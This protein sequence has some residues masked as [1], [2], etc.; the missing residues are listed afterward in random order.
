MMSTISAEIEVAAPVRV[1]YDQ[2][3]QFEE[4]PA[5]MRAVAAVE[6]LDDRT[7]RWVIDIGGMTRR[8]DA[9]IIDQVPDDHI[10]WESVDETVHHGRVDFIPIDESHTRVSLQMQW[11]PETFLERA[12]AALAIDDN[13][14]RMDLERFKDIVEG[15]G[16]LAA[17][18]RGEIHGADV[19]RPAD[20]PRPTH[21]F[22]RAPDTADPDAR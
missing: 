6:Q 8:F 1:A 18:W 10:E 3:T 5:F 7:M 13:A 20:A 19:V 2:W 12:G 21:G 14:A 11:M 16:T 15:G 9:R 4:F 17:G 22:F